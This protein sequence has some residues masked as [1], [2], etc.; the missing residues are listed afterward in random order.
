MKKSNKFEK[1]LKIID[2]LH[3]PGGCPWDRKQT[4][5]SILKNL[6][7]EAKEFEHAVVRRD[8]DGMKE[9]LGDLLLQVLFHS[10]IASKRNRFDIYDV[11]DEL[12]QKLIRRHPHV[13]SGLKVKNVKEVLKNWEKIKR[14]EKIKKKR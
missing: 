2:K 6:F 9:E 12:I 4:H 14:Q 13:F 10:K 11:I 3:G 5:K 8:Y 7:E 1:L